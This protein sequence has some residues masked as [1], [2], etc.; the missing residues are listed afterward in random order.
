[1]ST[2]QKDTPGSKEKSTL[3]TTNYKPV[4][5]CPPDKKTPQ[6]QKRNLPWKLLTIWNWTIFF[7]VECTNPDFYVNLSIS[8]DTLME[9]P[10]I[11]FCPSFGENLDI[12]IIAAKLRDLLHKVEL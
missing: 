2:R 11:F 4:Y 10:I 3:K 12:K 5:I 1:M 6:A 8:D 9:L 7:N